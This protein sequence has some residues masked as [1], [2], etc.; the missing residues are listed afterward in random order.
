LLKN[1]FKGIATS[2]GVA[3]LFLSCTKNN[4]NQI[5]AFSHPPGSPEVVADTFVVL[6]SDSAVVR[7]RLQ[8]PSLFIYS[9]EDDPYKEFPNGFLIE[10]FDNKMHV[11]S[12]I[13]A[14][15]GKYYEKKQLWEAK[16]NVVALTE[17]GDSLLTEH[18]FWD[19]K[20]DLL[21]SDLFVKVIKPDKVLTGVGF[22]SDVHMTYW[23]FEAPK[24]HFY[25]DVE[26]GEKE[27]E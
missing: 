7:F 20:K 4:I 9:D 3:V 11:T 5:K 10:K 12:S 22:E 8:T 13:K 14:D 24:G 18:L 17:S 23:K 1:I 16:Q 6:F 15:Y 21:Y 2:I 25:V 19:E 27:K 26:E